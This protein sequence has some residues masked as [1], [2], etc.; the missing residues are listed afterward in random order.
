MR[1]DEIEARIAA[2]R[3]TVETRAAE[4]S[5]KEVDALTEESKK[6]NAER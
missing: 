1:I 5:D 2:I 4:L 6:L 3:E